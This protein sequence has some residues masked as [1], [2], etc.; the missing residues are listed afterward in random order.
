[1]KNI[2][3]GLLVGA[4]IYLLLISSVTLSTNNNWWDNS[5]L[6]REEISIPIDTSLEEAKYQPVDIHITF[7]NPCWAV[8]ETMHSIRVICQDEEGF[9]ELES[10]I[11]DLHFIDD[12]HIDSCGVVFL[13]P[14]FTDGEEE[15][16][17]YYDDNE[18]PAPNYM[19]HV[20]V[21]E[22]YYRYEPIPGYPFESRYFKV[23]QHGYIVYG[24]A[25][26]G[27]FLGFSTAHQITKFKDN[28][29][30]VS[31]PKNAETWASF[32]FFYYYGKDVSEFS[33]TIQTLLSREIILDGN[34]MV[35]FRIKSS[36]P[37][38]DVETIATYTY[39]YC[40]T[41]DKRIYVHVKHHALSEMHIGMEEDVG[42]ICGLQA[43]SM[44]SPSIEE[45]NFGRMY[46]YFHV[47]AEDETI[48]EYALDMDPEYTPEGIPVLT[49]KDD[50]DLGSHAWASFDDGE[51]GE[52][53]AIILASQSNIT[54]GTD[55]RDGVQVEALEG[56]TPGVLGLETDIISFY[57][58]RN[59]FE[60]GQPIDLDIP[61]DF[62]VEYDA[63]FFSA[64]SDGYQAVDRESQIFQ[65]LNPYRVISERHVE[66]EER[67]EEETY[68]LK[69]FIHLAASAPIGNLLSL[70][71]GINISYITVELYREGRFIAS[72][73][74]ERISIQ[75]PTTTKN[76][77][78][79]L[80]HLFDWRNTSFFK[81]VVFNN[82]KPGFYL[83]K[84]YRNNPLG[85]EKKFIGFKTVEVKKDTTT[86]IFCTQQNSILVKLVDQQGDPIRDA[87]IGILY[88]NTTISKEYSNQNG[89]S[90][91]VFPYSRTYILKVLHK[92]FLVYEEEFHPKLFTPTR[93][94]ITIPLYDFKIKVVDTWNLPPSYILTCWL[95]SEEMITPCKL[96]PDYIDDGIY[97]FKNLSSAN[98]HLYLNYK[99]FLVEEEVEIP[100]MDSID[101]VFPAEYN[102]STRIL[103]DRGLP[104]TYYTL[105]LARGGVSKTF[106][107]NYM[108]I[109]PGR[110]LMEVQKDNKVI[111]RRHIVVVESRSIELVSSKPSILPLILIFIC[112][113]FLFLGLLETMKRKTSWFRFL[114][115]SLLVFS[116]LFPWWSLRGVSNQV[117][118]K[119]DIYLLPPSIISFY[120]TSS[121]ICGEKASLTEN[122]LLLLYIFPLSIILSGIL[123]IL[124][125]H[126]KKHKFR[127]LLKILSI[128]LLVVSIA[129]FS[130]GFSR[131]TAITVGSF[132]GKGL[133]QVEVPGEETSFTTQADWSPSLGLIC[134]LLS[135]ILLLISDTVTHRIILRGETEDKVK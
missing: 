62:I 83:L 65:T 118:A 110:Y 76:P 111:G 100:S 95:S 86:H 8:N 71:T 44:R 125:F 17:V 12:S 91:L 94:T 32:D 55:E 53:H 69:A 99:S 120:K 50:I 89:E 13:I 18:K 54:T 2:G 30:E 14:G 121:I 66:R 11:Y 39:Y 20:D 42:N 4:T 64:Y 57:F 36:T 41:K 77:L 87:E 74:A 75:P 104:I 25:F 37:R 84:V 106:D 135:I 43:G 117:E 1:M 122:I 112:V 73:V 78:K 23:T 29:T 98:Y 38:K 105:L 40:P 51:T 33:S 22:A 96:T 113:T 26:Q 128:M 126:T 124:I 7:S 88:E 101:I 52:A 61:R 102:V 60:E 93:R 133:Y 48:K 24:V 46:P 21:E 58:S 130:Y 9:H 109:P 27:E 79:T 129:L 67:K 107:T 92:G 63:E 56:S 68:K 19:D 16:Y 97:V 59:G 45:L 127:L 90:I 3:R 72:D 47:Y 114:V 131:I 31:S 5:W 34:L 132:I 80:L 10:Q 28:T 85:G 103:D 81:K 82:L 6:F 123:L 119:T 116:L 49:V 108:V 35:R 115:I 15:Y 134:C 70:L